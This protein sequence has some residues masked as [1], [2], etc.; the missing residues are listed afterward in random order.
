MTPDRWR[1]VE[2]IYRGALEREPASRSEFVRMESAGD[3]RLGSTVERLL[4]DERDGI[5]PGTR[6]GQY[7]I[8]AVAGEG[9]SGVVYRAHDSK[10]N[11][12]VAVKFL[13]RN[14]EE[15]VSRGRFQREGRMASALNHP[16]ILTVHDVGEH[17]GRSYL[18]T[19]YVDGGTLR[20]W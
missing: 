11:R 8:Q 3:E 20:D 4:E 17:N 15:E 12:T 16:H 5:G 6:L 7:E 18:V 19:E 9:G 1:R 14:Q 10:L 13:S 2:A